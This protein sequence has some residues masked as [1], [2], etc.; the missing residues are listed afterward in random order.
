VRRNCE[1]SH[2]VD[3]VH[4]ANAAPRPKAFS[5]PSGSKR[6]SSER[7]APVCVVWERSAVARSDAEQ[8]VANGDPHTVI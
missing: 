1:R 6:N 2:R 5:G 8:K 4:I 7:I 3:S